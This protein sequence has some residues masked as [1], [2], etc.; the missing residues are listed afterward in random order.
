MPRRARACPECGS[1]DRTGWASGEDLEYE[2]IEIPDA[3]DPDEWER[4]AGRREV[5]SKRVGLIAALVAGGLVLL[6][7]FGLLR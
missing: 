6:V 5:R 7:V 4:E 1:D 2:S 3:Y